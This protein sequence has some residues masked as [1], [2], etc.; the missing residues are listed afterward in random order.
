MDF[1]HLRNFS[2]VELVDESNYFSGGISGLLVVMPA[3]PDQDA[4]VRVSV[5][6]AT[7][8]P[9][10]VTKLN[11]VKDVAGLQLQAPD[12]RKVRQRYVGKPCLGI[13]LTIRV[14]RDVEIG[15][16][17]INTHNM[18][19]QIE[20]GLC[21]AHG[22]SSA[23]STVITTV[24]GSVKAACWSSR[25]TRVDTVSGSIEGTYALRDLL[26]LRSRSGSI[27]IR[28]A[29]KPADPTAPK[30][31]SFVALSQSGSAHVVFPT[32]DLPDRDYRTRVECSSSSITGTYIHGTATLMTSNAGSITANLLPYTTN[33]T[34]STLHTESHSG[35]TNLRILSPYRKSGTSI[36]GL[37]SSHISSSGSLGLTL[38]P[39][40]QGTIN[41]EVRSGH[42]DVAGTDLTWYADVPIGSSGRR[43]VVGRG[44]GDSRLDFTTNSGNVAIHATGF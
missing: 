3:E 24:H 21:G 16:W 27:N 29:P 33:I 25:E 2:F 23:D 10:R 37:R 4:D 43:V 19:V 9:W 11:Y 36:K 18:N 20:D 8:E 13:A 35:S 28:A 17:R 15:H 7:T 31:A 44:H 34:G 26:W 40:W 32:D 30:P 39:E 41:G 5:G 22:S 14:R 42:I 1:A 12:V 6:L 38:P